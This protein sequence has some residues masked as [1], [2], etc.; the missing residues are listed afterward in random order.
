MTGL[1]DADSNTRKLARLMFRFARENDLLGKCLSLVFDDQESTVQRLL[2]SENLS[3]D[4]NILKHLSR[5]TADED[6]ISLPHPPVKATELE[7]VQSA[8]SIQPGEDLKQT[9]ARVFPDSIKPSER[10]LSVMGP[11]RIVQ[12]ATLNADNKPMQQARL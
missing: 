5:S 11:K 12:T 3:S 4:L 6:Q 2:Q 10:R 7:R 1:R 9:E 8:S